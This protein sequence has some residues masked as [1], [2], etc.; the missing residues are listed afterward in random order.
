MTTRPNFYRFHN[1]EQAILPFENEEYSS[2][3]AQLRERLE[4]QGA[5]AAVFTSMHKRSLLFGLPILCFWSSLW[6]G[7]DRGRLA[8]TISAGIDGGAALAA[9][10]LAITSPTL[11]GKE[12]IFGAQCVRLLVRKWWLVLKV[13]T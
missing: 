6:I 8:S 3:L 13:I 7:C 5:S 2:R 9:L 4:S 12:I 10:F 1:G 11:I